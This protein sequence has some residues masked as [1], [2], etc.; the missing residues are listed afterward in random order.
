M[1]FF[2]GVV[3][4][5][6]GPERVCVD[7]NRRLTAGLP[8]VLFGGCHGAGLSQGRSRGIR[9][10]RNGA[11]LYRAF[12]GH[13]LARRIRGVAVDGNALVDGPHALSVVLHR[14]GTCGARQ[15]GGRFA[16]GHRTSAAARALGD[17]QWGVARVLDREHTF[18][19]ST[20]LDRAIVVC[21]LVHRDDGSCATNGLGVRLC[22][23]AQRQ[24]AEAERK[25][26]LFH[27]G[28]LVV[29]LLYAESRMLG[30]DKPGP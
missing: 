2:L 13:H 30:C 19:V 22:E 20:L 10:W 23:N 14:D 1:V 15:D 28:V 11:G 8:S 12:D 7:L 25:E 27:E 24:Q 16:L 21:F 6:E 4:K 9:R 5:V 26:V 18:A 29:C 3:P 17:D